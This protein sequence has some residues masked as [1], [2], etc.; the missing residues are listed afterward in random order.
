MQ[1]TNHNLFV[2][3]VF[4]F[5]LVKRFCVRANFAIFLRAYHSFCLTKK[6][7]NLQGYAT[8]NIYSGIFFFSFLPLYL[9]INRS[10]TNLLIQKSYFSCFAI[11]QLHYLYRPLHRSLLF[12]HYVWPLLTITEF[13][14][15]ILNIAFDERAYALANEILCSSVK[16]AHFVNKN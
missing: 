11:R 8:P 4:S 7:L 5:Y 15:T 3:R 13:S 1:V 9:E 14:I 10:K 12:N 16:L 2:V 6:Y